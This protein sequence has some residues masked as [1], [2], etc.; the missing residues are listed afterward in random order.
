MN[1]S[2]ARTRW[3]SPARRTSRFVLVASRASDNLPQGLQ[4]PLVEG[5][6][7]LNRLRPLFVVGQPVGDVA[8][9]I[10]RG[11]CSAA[12][13]ANAPSSGVP[14]R[15]CRLASSSIAASVPATC[16]MAAALE[17]R[18]AMS[19]SWAARPRLASSR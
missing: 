14:V 11:R 4:E 19:T 5:S 6:L 9:E 12:S 3:W 15:A 2:K 10:Y 1:R 13:R 18:M 17:D 16:S 8:V 7:L